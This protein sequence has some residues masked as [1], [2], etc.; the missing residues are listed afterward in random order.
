[1]NI[2]HGSDLPGKGALLDDR[3]THLTTMV[4]FTE[5]V[6]IGG[7]DCKVHSFMSNLIEK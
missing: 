5:S 1:M 4:C 3:K 7:F 6:V 2:N